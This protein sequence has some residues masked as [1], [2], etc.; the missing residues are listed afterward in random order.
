MSFE[1]SDCVNVF[2]PPAWVRPTAVQ[3]VL[4]SLRLRARGTKTVLG[5]SRSQVLHV[6]D[7]VRLLGFHTP[8]PAPRARAILLH[9][10]E[11]SSNSTYIRTTARTLY[12]AGC[13]IFRLNLRDHGPSH[14]LNEGIFLAVYLD[15]AVEAAT[16]AA[17]QTLH[18]PVFLCGFSLGGNFALRIAA[19][20]ADAPPD[21]LRR[22]VA[23]SPAID[24]IRATE[25]IDDSPF[26][27]WYF[28]RKW[29][30][31]LLRKQQLFPSRYDFS[32]LSPRLNLMQMTERLIP[33]Y[34]RYPDA[35]TY[36]AAYAVNRDVY[37]RIRVPTTVI[38]AEDDPVI[39]V[40]DLSALPSNPAVERIIH[41]FGGHN[42]FI[43]GDISSTWY[44][45]WLV[46]QL[47]FS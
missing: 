38:T 39:P 1:D 29:R 37:T 44:E 15:E 18:L 28:R 20:W 45:K 41:P 21:N 19:R 33:R 36:L 10:W 27:L 35:L 6:A 9:G 42:G 25:R 8:H 12:Q 40:A 4:A 3:T 47:V 11:G 5:R 46:R 34:S 24:P 30:R 16:Q 43:E 13:D 7:G 14:H 26:L 23:I 2:H 22:V 31:S 17:A 32:K